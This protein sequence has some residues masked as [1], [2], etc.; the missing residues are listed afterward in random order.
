[1]LLTQQMTRSSSMEISLLNNHLNKI[2][3]ILS[4][5]EREEAI[6]LT[7]KIR[8]KNKMALDNLSKA[9]QLFTATSVN[10]I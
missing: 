3:T 8:E 6:L 4:F 10:A 5:L 1:M 7:N 9:N 2:I